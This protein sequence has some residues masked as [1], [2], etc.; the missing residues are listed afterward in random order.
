MS[1]KPMEVVP[2]GLYPPEVQPEEKF[3]FL[4][5]KLLHIKPDKRMK[6]KPPDNLSHAES[7]EPAP[8]S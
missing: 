2:D 6:G 8:E 1:K 3:N 5:R 4:G 7:S